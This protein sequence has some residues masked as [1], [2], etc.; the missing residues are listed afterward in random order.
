M[1]TGGAHFGDG[2]E[3]DSDPTMLASPRGSR[4]DAAGIT[5][6]QVGPDEQ[7]VAAGDVDGWLAGMTAAHVEIL[8][9]PSYCW[10][11]A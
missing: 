6:P 9:L 1:Y 4:G 3:P 7:T 5:R 2:V 10:P 8:S 11:R